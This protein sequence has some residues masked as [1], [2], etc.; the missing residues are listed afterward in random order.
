MDV[1]WENHNPTILNRQGPDVGT[2]Y[3]SCI[4]YHDTTQLE[5]AKKLKEK[6]QN[7]Y[8]NEIVTEI[9]P[10]E[11]FYTAEDYHQNYFNNNK[12]AP[13]CNFVIKPKLEKFLNGKK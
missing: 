5:I 6:I 2:Q 8:S 10:L 13:Y 1:F 4:F 7:N 9:L 12:N 3:R 11:K